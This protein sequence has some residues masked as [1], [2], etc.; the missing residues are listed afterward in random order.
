[1]YAVRFFVNVFRIQLCWPLWTSHFHS[2]CAGFTGASLHGLKPHFSSYRDAQEWSVWACFINYKHPFVLGVARKHTL[3]NTPAQHL[4]RPS[5]WKWG[6]L[7]SGSIESVAIWEVPVFL[8]SSHFCVYQIQLVLCWRAIFTRQ[9][10]KE[11]S[12]WRD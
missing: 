2:D 8:S 6:C 1:M 5:N 7:E 12:N 4:L 9:L 3:S 10:L 11:E